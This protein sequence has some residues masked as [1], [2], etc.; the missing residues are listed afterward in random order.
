MA[1]LVDAILQSFHSNYEKIAISHHSRAVT[2]KELHAGSLAVCSY[3]KSKGLNKGDRVA[4]YAENSIEYVIVYYGVLIAGGVVVALNTAAKANDLGNWIRHSGS[5]WLFA[6]GS[7]K[8][9]DSLLTMLDAKMKY[10][11]IGGHEFHQTDVV[12]CFEKV[13][14]APVNKSLPVVNG[15]DT[16]TIIYTSGTT[17][18]PKGVTLTHENLMSNMT[19][20][21][22]YMPLIKHDKCLCVL[23]FYYSYGNSVL[24]TH[25]MVGATLVLEN[26]FVYPHAILKKMQDDKITSFSGV[27]ST[28]AILLRRTSLS[29]F[30]LSSLRYMTQAG[31]AMMTSYIEEI[32]KM[33]P[34]VEFIV[35]YGQ[36]EATARLT[37]LPFHQLDKRLASA[38]KAIPGVTLEIRDALGNKLPEGKVGEV[39]ASGTN[40]MKGYWRDLELTSS[41]L[42][43]GW[44]K[45]GDLAY[46]DKDDY[47]Y[48]VGRESE[49]I[50]SGAH[51]ISPLEI[52]EVI[53]Q[54]EGVEEVAVIGKADEI[55]G[56]IIKA[57]VV[58][59]PDSK[60]EKRLIQQ[61]CKKN[62]A[63]FKLPK[64]IE[65]ISVLPRT[66]SGKIKRF[67]LQ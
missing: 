1:S 4:L 52:E 65:F 6:E 38:G 12:E 46:R 41:V 19:S 11:M 34:E 9:M 17:G 30:D 62:L 51:R 15:S 32:R 29:K 50:K 28:Y 57:F 35:M 25:M 43:D 16:A 42:V 67:E 31:G 66:P 44:L 7:N 20:I 3:L 55:L 58:L 54:C 53:M 63:I 2:Y 18:Q 37:Y 61:H 40:I 47:L 14:A 23:P 45:T 24:H 5:S 48:I 13:L 10:V 33:L 27:P 36:T 49:M 21:L 59:K 64:L 56:Q 26:S 22:D 8:E 39:Y 60:I